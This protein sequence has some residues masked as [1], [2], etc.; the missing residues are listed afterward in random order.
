[1]TLARGTQPDDNAL[2]AWWTVA[3]LCALF[4]VSMLDRFILMVLA[5][6]MAQSI[7][8]TDEQTGLL[9]GAG[10][11]IVY[12]LG[13]ILIARK[14]DK[15]NRKALVVIGVLIWS[16]STIGSAFVSSFGQLLVLRSGVAVGEAFLTPAAVSIIADLFK[17]ERRG[18]ATSIYVSSGALMTPG[19]FLVGAAILASVAGLSGV[20][21]LEPWRV[22][23]IAV[24]V[25]GIFLAMVLHFTV[26]EPER[27]GYAASG[28]SSAAPVDSGFF[29]G[30]PRLWITLTLLHGLTALAYMGWISWTSTVLMRNFGMS[31]EYAGQIFGLVGM[32]GS[33]AG[34]L[35]WPALDLAISKWRGGRSA[36]ALLY[37]SACIG[38]TA[39]VIVT[40]FA[41]S[42]TMIMMAN[43][44]ALFC[45]NGTAVL[46]NVMVQNAS[47][48]PNRARLAALVILSNGLIGTGIG[49]VLTP[50]VAR[51]FYDPALGLGLAMSTVA[52]IALPILI[53]LGIRIQEPYLRAVEEGRS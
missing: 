4:A 10:F 15:G 1:M 35:C 28:G 20:T 34:I 51:H 5:K 44:V 48:S 37:F 2:H 26:R 6:P 42:V 19:A 23:L 13:G 39:M 30:N 53:V 38:S 12:T 27:L 18:F 7:R 24:G 14:L 31:V 32:I 52:A 9:F 16:C 8:I 29:A 3:V 22:T 43:V 45:I 33:A 11:A 46:P 49:P 36:T 25:P 47:P 17:P 50:F 41:D 40:G 21:G